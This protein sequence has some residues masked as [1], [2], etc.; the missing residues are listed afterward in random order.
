MIT[1]G[2]GFRQ[3]LRHVPKELLIK[4]NAKG[5]FDILN[6]IPL[7]QFKVNNGGVHSNHLD[8][9]DALVDWLNKKWDDLLFD[10]GGNYEMA[11]QK[12]HEHLVGSVDVEGL[13]PALRNALNEKSIK[14]TQKVNDLF[15]N[16]G[17]NIQNDSRFAVDYIIQNY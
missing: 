8:Y 1:A 10:T 3:Y 2:N 11:A 14:G 15:K 6:A 16:L 9:T 7:E 17:T 4:F 12:M 13:L 5:D